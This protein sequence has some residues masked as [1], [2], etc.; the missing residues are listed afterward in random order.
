MRPRM[1]ARR[2]ARRGAALLYATLVAVAIAGMCVALLT[3]NLATNKS[4]VQSRTAERAFYAAEAGLS[5]A[6]VQ[7]TEGVTPWPEEATSLGS[8]DSPS[9]FGKSS[10]WVDVE[11][12]DSRTYALT[13]T[14]VDGTLR[15]RLLL[16]LG[17]A[18]SGFFQYA[19]FGAEGVVL[20]SN[21]FIDS[22]DS[23]QGSYESQV[24]AG[25]EFAKENGH[26][27]SNADIVLKSNTEVHGDAIPGPGHVVDDTAPGAY[28]SG[29]TDPAEEEFELVPIVPPPAA[30]LG[31]HAGA[32]DLVVGPGVSVHYSSITMQGGKKLTI[33]GPATLVVDDFLLKS[34]SELVFET[35]GGPVEL[36]ATGDFVLQSNSTVTTE[37]NSA[38]DVTLLLAG[39][40]MTGVPP[41]KVQLGSN[42]QFVGAIY[43]PNAKF[44]LG[45]NFD[46]YGSIM[47]GF[48][49]LSSNGE[50]HYD[51]ALMYDG[52]GSSDVFETR[53]WRRL[54]PD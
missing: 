48:L 38:L 28:V 43:A 9:A 39:D 14:G 13:S 53:L 11:P 31:S 20:D 34:N 52:W 47:C 4:R 5:D 22:Y 1:K 36:Y 30:S 6:F 37:T 23:A 16:V 41:A 12:L 8:E 26:V 21:A 46:V 29:S 7:L 40:N 19:A 45:S 54:P 49:D 42:S 15:E 44:S 32:S 51:E 2:A 33:V 25:N 17:E 35:S 18:P 24:K 10:Y 27:G 3:V 50:I